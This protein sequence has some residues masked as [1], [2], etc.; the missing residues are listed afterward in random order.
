MR[1]NTQSVDVFETNLRRHYL[2]LTLAVCGPAVPRTFGGVCVECHAGGP[3]TALLVGLCCW[4]AVLGRV[5]AV[6]VL[7]LLLLLLM[8]LLLLLLLFFFF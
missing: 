5:L 2:S 7:L 8:L 6:F 1:D 4:L 3:L